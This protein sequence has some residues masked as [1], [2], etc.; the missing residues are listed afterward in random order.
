MLDRAGPGRLGVIL[1]DASRTDDDP[2]Q[3]VH[4]HSSCAKDWLKGATMKIE[5]VVF[6][7]DG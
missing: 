6:G 4:A 7:V 3:Q 5:R 1:R 2:F